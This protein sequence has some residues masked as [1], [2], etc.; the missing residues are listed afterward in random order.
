MILLAVL[1]VL[2][3]G[4]ILALPARIRNLCVLAGLLF[5]TGAAGLE[6]VGGLFAS[7]SG[8]ESFGFVAESTVE[9]FLEML[10]ITVFIY[11]LMEYLRRYV[12]EILIP[13]VGKKLS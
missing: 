4:F 2:Y 9:E 11:A 6:M 13:P 1:G 12:P 3:A 5:V 8:Q 7:S 10:G